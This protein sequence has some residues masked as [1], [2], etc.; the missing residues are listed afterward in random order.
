M[1]AEVRREKARL[2]LRH[3]QADHR[4]LDDQEADR[5]RKARE[6]ES[7]AEDRE[8]RR[9][10]AEEEALDRRDRE[11]RE[12]LRREALRRKRDQDVSSVVW[13]VKARIGAGMSFE[14]LAEVEAAIHR[15]M[16]RLPEGA[17]LF[18]LLGAAS[19]IALP[20]AQ[21]AGQRRAEL[22]KSKAEA[23]ALAEKRLSRK[24]VL[25]RQGVE[26]AAGEI[27]RGDSW[28]RFMEGQRVKSAL[29]ERLSGAEDTEELED[30]VD[31]ILECG[32]ASG[33]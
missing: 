16:E 10:E 29:E 1:A 8:Y 13:T 5:E 4:A 19:S 28:S 7:E 18:D 17:A 2:E 23:E 30:F 11:R 26:Y 24:A 20:F 15:G 31:T 3:V 33:R 14:E 12:E 9:I 27:T 6:R 22:A 21:R 25:V 32:A